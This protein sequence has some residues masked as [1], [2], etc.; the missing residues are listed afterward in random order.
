MLIVILASCSGD[1][2]SVD[3]STVDLGR[4]FRVRSFHKDIRTLPESDTAAVA[5]LIRVYGEFWADYSEDILKLGAFDDTSTVAALRG[6]INHPDILETLDA[7]DTT[8]GS[9][10]RIARISMELENGFKRF[11]SLMPAEPVPDIILMPSGFNNA[12]Y[13]RESYIGLG[14][15]MFL[16]HEHPILNYLPPEK[17]PQ[18]RK[19]RMHPDLISANAFRGWMLVNFSDRG[20]TGAMLIED[21]LFWGKVLWLMDQCMPELHDHL[22]MDWTPGDLAW[23]EANEKSIWIELQPQGVLFEK[24]RTVYNRWLN[25]GPFTRAGDIPQESPDR[26]GIWMGWR[27]IDDY[28]NS[29]PETNLDQLFSDTEYA[30]YLKSYRP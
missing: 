23:A 5:K 26:L 15:E 4:E 7:I 9:D 22:L 2:W 11:H 28:M 12:V 13:P 29:N 25:E 27:I 18:Y 24:N 16:G 8:S 3:P 19:M 30:P 14:L 17:F 10:E 6:F 21:I 1:R 20:Y